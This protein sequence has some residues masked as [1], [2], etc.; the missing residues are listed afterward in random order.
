MM[1]SPFGKYFLLQIPGWII[2]AIILWSAQQWLA[3]S[4]WLV[5]VGVSAWI[6]KDLALYPIVRTAY[7]SNVKT[8]IER[9]IGDRGVVQSELAPRG[10]VRVRGELWSAEIEAGSQPLAQGEP[11]RILGAQ[12]VILIVTAD[13]LDEREHRFLKMNE[14]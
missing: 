13:L 11:V 12:G 6:L 14:Q 4:P 3:V 8:G 1:K 10:K 9:L 5:G 2:A 7:E